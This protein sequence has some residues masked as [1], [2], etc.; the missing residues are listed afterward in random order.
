MCS[1]SSMARLIEATVASMLTTTPLRSPF[2]GCEPMP[3]MSMPSS[4]TSPTMAQIFVVPM[5]RPTRMSPVFAIDHLR[6]SWRRRASPNL[7]PSRT[8]TTATTFA[9]RRPPAAP[10][11]EARPALGARLLRRA[12]RARQPHGHPVRAPPVVEMQ[13][14]RALP[15]GVDRRE[16]ALQSRELLGKL[17]L[18]Q[19]DL[20]ALF[21][22]PERRPVIR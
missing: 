14:F 9:P 3:M 8:A 10:R 15:L 1:A 16:H 5:S 4:V 18:S 13:H 20:D 7:R 12:L 22:G 19:P 21:A 6:A 17:P 2:D 11:A